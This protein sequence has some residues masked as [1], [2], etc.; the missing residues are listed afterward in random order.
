[1][2][3]ETEKAFTEHLLKCSECM[4]TLLSLDKD[5]FIMDKVKHNKIPRRYAVGQTT[6][7]LVSNGIEL[8][9]G[10]GQENGF[11]QFAPLPARGGVK[12]SAYRLKQGDV[13]VDI[14]SEGR[15]RFNI[16]FNG[17]FGKKVRLFRNN[18]LIEAR[19]N[20]R[21]RGVTVYNL[22]KGNYSLVI[23]DQDSIKF[24]VE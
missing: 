14:M 19:S 8:I 24:I 22:E 13:S 23:N 1:M 3:G 21:D 7:Q 17:V 6:F 11:Q 2:D 10:F 12:G 16:T 18:R 4:N 15:D 9:K 5:L 20:I